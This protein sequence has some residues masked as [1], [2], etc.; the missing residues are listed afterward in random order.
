VL[1]K[2]L[3]AYDPDLPANR[4]ETSGTQE[5]VVRFEKEGRRLTRG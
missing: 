3:Q 2:L 5:V 4:R 1:I